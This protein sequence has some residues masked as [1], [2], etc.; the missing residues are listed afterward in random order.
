VRRFLPSWRQWLLLFGLG[1]GLG[2]ISFAVLYSVIDVPKPNDE[3]L[4]QSTIVYYAD[5]RS[6]IG[7]FGEANRTIIAID[8]I[9]LTLRQAVM[10]AEDRNFYKEGGFSVTGIARAA[11][12]DLAGGSLQGGSTITQQLV[13]N[14][15]LTQDRTISRKVNEFIVSIKI[16]QALS[17][18]EILTDYLNTIYFGRGAYGVQ[19]AARAYFGPTARANTLTPSQAAVLASIIRSPGGYSPENHL[20]KLMDRWNFVLDGEVKEGWMTPADRAT[21][22]FPTI[23][24]RKSASST[25]GPAGYLTAYVQSELS[26][27][28]YSDDDINRSGLRITTTF[29]KNA[30][31]AAVDAVNAERPKKDAVGVRVGL[32][33][34]NPATGGIVAMY[35]GPDYGH[36]QYINDATQSIAQAGSTF[37]AFTLVAALEN[38]I[39][40]SSTWDGH[41]GRVF[42]DA[43]GAKTNPIPNE[44]GKSYGHISLLQAT[45]D[46][47]NTVFMDVENQ[48]EVGAAKVVDAARRAGIPDKVVIDPVL[49]ATLGVASPTALD[50][51]SA[52]ATLASGG[53]LTTPTAIAKIIGSNNGLLYELTPK[54]SR[55]IDQGIV[56]QVDYAL[57]KVVTDGTG[58]TARKVGRPVAAK[59]GT[60]DSNLSAWFVGYTPQLATSVVLF[61]TESDGKTR[62]SMNGVGG[63]R[64]INGAGYPASIWT[65]YMTKAVKGMP[66]VAFPKPPPDTVSPSPTPSVSPSPSPSPSVSTSPSPSA[67]SSPSPSVS[68]SQSPSPSVSPPI[69]PGAPVVPGDETG[70]QPG[71]LAPGDRRLPG[72]AGTR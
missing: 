6:E 35:G 31:Q 22:K 62:K 32:A 68:I 12:N 71:I 69:V 72:A 63:L 64:R 60:T 7:R 43:N 8:Q 59:T 20:A 37:K 56:S 44:D 19:A 29:D 53:S 17:K 15:Y 13:K 21:A 5:G 52:Y 40:L 70:A 9:P 58:T 25:G 18:D 4:A 42:T 41:S 3:A 23:A 46:S 54:P 45:E 34:V 1:T 28:G 14:Y 36:P 33:S 10:S 65:S 49:S 61:R 2:V 30:E 26:S 57:Q 16:D 55:T 51:A 48:P 66:V 11:W 24:V 39:T 50:M 38:G 67:S 47:V 27:L